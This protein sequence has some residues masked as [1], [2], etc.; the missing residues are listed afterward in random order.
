MMVIS[1]NRNIMNRYN[2]CA[3]TKVTEEYVWPDMSELCCVFLKKVFEG[4]CKY[5]ILTYIISKKEGGNK[6]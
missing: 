3:E 4:S 6:R 2:C 5:R 1:P